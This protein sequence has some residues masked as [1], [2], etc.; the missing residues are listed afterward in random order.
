MLKPNSN[1]KD[2]FD[3][4]RALAGSSAP[5]INLHDHKISEKVDVNAEYVS[6]VGTETLFKKNIYIYINT[7]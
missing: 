4:C 3:F 7:A 2:K 6:D 5:P 1:R